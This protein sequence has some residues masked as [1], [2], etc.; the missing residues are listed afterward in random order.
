MSLMQESDCQIEILYFTDSK[1]SSREFTPARKNASKKYVN[2]PLCRLVYLNRNWAE[3]VYQVP[4]V[5]PPKQLLSRRGQLSFEW[6]WAYKAW[7]LNARLSL[8]FVLRGTWL[9]VLTHNST[10]LRGYRFMTWSWETLAKCETEDSSIDGNWPALSTSCAGVLGDG[11]DGG[12]C[13]LAFTS[14]SVMKKAVVMSG[15][16]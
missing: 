16:V 1:L 5:F 9:K 3:D 7:K 4:S 12:K 6:E 11:G 14:K 13:R 15:R 10:R 2:L 8:L